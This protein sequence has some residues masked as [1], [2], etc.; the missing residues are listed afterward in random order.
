MTT[1]YLCFELD[2]WV[3]TLDAADERLR[4]QFSTASLK[5]FGIDTMHEAIVAAG[6]ILHYLDITQHTH[7]AHINAIARL[8][9]ER[10]VRM[11]PFTV[12]NL[13]L[14]EPLGSEG[15]SLLGVLDRTARLR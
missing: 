8:E 12:R 5:G 2:D 11:D 14:L 13:E 15:R 6:A 4:R 3:F 7:T 9:A 1:R 10:Y